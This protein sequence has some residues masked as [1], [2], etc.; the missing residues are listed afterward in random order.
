MSTICNTVISD[1]SGKKAAALNTLHAIFA[2]GALLG[3]IFLYINSDFFNW[4]WK[5]TARMIGALGLIVLIVI[6]VSKLPGKLPGKEKAVGGKGILRSKLFWI[7]TGILFFYLAAEASI[8]GWFVTYFTDLGILSPNISSF[9]PTMLWLM[10]MLG[11]VS[12]AIFSERVNKNMLILGLGL[13]FTAFFTAMLFSKSGPVIIICL[14]GIGFSMAGIYPTTFSSMKDLSSSAA[15]GLCIGVATV[16]AIIMPSIIGAVADAR[17]LFGGVAV[18]LTACAGMV[19][20]MVMKL[21]TSKE[22]GRFSVS[23]IAKD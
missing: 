5:G 12:C 4:S 1:V 7:N 8:I 20:L 21:W 18:I 9:T 19:A 17:G 22:N 10:I 23:S 15:N 11:R 2:I 3:P 13:A 16:G 14:L 6:A